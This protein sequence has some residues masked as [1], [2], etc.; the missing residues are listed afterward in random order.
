MAEAVNTELIASLTQV[1]ETNNSVL[2]ELS[3]LTKEI[4]KLLIGKKADAVKTKE[5]IATTVATP[6]QEKSATDVALEQKEPSP[7]IIYDIDSNAFKKLEK[8]FENISGKT[9]KIEAPAAKKRPSTGGKGLLGDLLD[10]FNI[11]D[12]LVKSAFG[13]LLSSGLLTALGGL[14]ASLALAIS[15]WFDTGPWKGTKKLIGEIGTKIFLPK[16]TKILTQFFPKLFETFTKGI[17]GIGKSAG[18]LITKLLPTTGVLGKLAAKFLGFFTPLLKRLPIIGTIINIGSAI[19]RFIQGDIIGG[20]ID[21]GSAIAVLIPG[22]G[23]AI[24]L[25][26]GLLNA[27]RDLTG[28]SKKTTGQQLAN[29]GSIFGKVIDWMKEKLKSV[30]NY[31]FG[32]IGRGIDQIKSGDYIRGIVTLAS[33]IPTFWWVESVYNW[34]A[35]PPPPKLVEQGKKETLPSD[36]VG[37]AWDWMKE[38][39]KKI[40]TNYFSKF[41]RG[42]EQ[43]KSGN[44]IQG[45]VTWAS[46]L[47]GMYWLESVYSWISGSQTQQ[48]T[49]GVQKE[50][51]QPGILSK[52]W[53]WM[54]EKIKKIFT[55]YFSKF[56]QAWEEIKSGDYLQGIITLASTVPGLWWLKATYNWLISADNSSPEQKNEKEPEQQGILSKAYSWLKQKIKNVF[57]KW[58]N[59]FSRGWEQIKSGKYFEGIITWA[60]VVP[61]FGWLTGLYNWVTGT[62]DSEPVE[63]E[64]SSIEGFNWG[65]IYSTIKD[66]IKKKLKDVLSKLR[67]LAF[68][69]N[70]LVDKIENF[71]GLNESVVEEDLNNFAQDTTSATTTPA[72]KTGDVSKP[73]QDLKPVVSQP[74]QQNLVSNTVAQQQIQKDLSFAVEQAQSSKDNLIPQTQSTVEQQ[75]IKQQQEAA[76]QAQQAYNKIDTPVVPAVQLPL[77]SSATNGINLIGKLADV[78]KNIPTGDT[79][80]SASTLLSN[81]VANADNSSINIYNQSSDRDIPYVERNKYRQQLLYIRGIL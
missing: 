75:A 59:K 8:L 3:S 70:K 1:A 39:T 12:L 54:K 63:E 17:Q 65:K 4:K 51:E 6:S 58:F 60:S 7:V 24:S 40:F 13:K 2:K 77:A 16:V 30:F 43:I 72:V 32:K 67:K 44:Y 81:A 62:E 73:K 78:I 21:I 76:Q 38:K 66:S 28:E 22:V 53:S 9:A 35:G 11:K 45:I 48:P 29:I 36:I 34:L 80:R 20:L 23:T 42:W 14:G 61:G 10:K 19:S 37:K 69:P 74:S 71:L 56:S 31:Y 33:F 25:A 26:L 52:A 68:V 5:P 18:G 64:S 49:D 47:P 55:G 27:G 50:P 46:T 41:G 57:N 15:S 79:V